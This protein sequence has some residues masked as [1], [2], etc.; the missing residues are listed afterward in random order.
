MP[1]GAFAR[2]AAP[3]LPSACPACGFA[4]EAGEKFCGGCG[5]TLAATVAGVAAPAEANRANG[6]GER[7][8]VTVLFADLVDY[9]RLSQQLDPED[10]HALLGRFYEVADEIVERF[11][12]SIDKHIGDSVMAVFG[13]P[14]AHDDDAIRAVRAAAEIQRTMPSLGSGSGSR[15]RCTSA[16]RRARSSPAASAAP[17][18]AR[19]R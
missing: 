6:D 15:W 9:T 2:N 3:G 16:S 7:R 5:A 12:G 13:A 11:G 14:V 8:P 18:I 17:G 10:V 1:D 19:T 4:N